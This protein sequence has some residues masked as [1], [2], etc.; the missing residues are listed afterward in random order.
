MAQNLWTREQLLLALDLYLCTPFSKQD[1]K[2]LPIIELAKQIGRTP[3]AVAMKL[4]NFSSL[5]PEEQK[6]DI[7]GFGNVSNLDREIWHQYQTNRFALVIEM[8]QALERHAANQSSVEID[9]PAFTIETDA[10]SIVNTRRGQNF[11]RRTVL[12]SYNNRCCITGNRIPAMLRASH[13]MPWNESKAHRLDPSNGLCLTADFDA[14]FD[15][16]LITFDGNYRLILSSRIKEFETNNH[17]QFNFIKREHQQIQQ[18]EKNMPSKE[19]IAWHREEVFL[20]T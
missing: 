16:G 8:E 18:P 15:R 4:S 2:H 1:R 10:Q 13:I 12:A 5:D 20:Q 17:I 11:F 14:A 19:H 3:S 7:K 6:R 9:G